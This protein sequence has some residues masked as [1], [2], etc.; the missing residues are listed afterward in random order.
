MVQDESSMLLVQLSSCK[1]R[2]CVYPEFAKYICVGGLYDLE[3]NTR[4][5]QTK[6][7]YVYG[8]LKA[9]QSYTHNKN[10]VFCKS[11][12]FSVK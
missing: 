5:L 3:K 7:F 12:E 9:L 6:L 8:V 2:N 4:G 11:V 10:H 1:R